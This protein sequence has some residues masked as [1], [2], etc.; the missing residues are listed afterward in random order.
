MNCVSPGV[1]NTDIADDFRRGVGAGVLDRAT[2]IAGR[3]AEPEE[4]ARPC[5]S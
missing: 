1:T 2:E 3:M 4:M 5:F